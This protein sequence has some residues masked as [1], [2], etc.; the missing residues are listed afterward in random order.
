MPDATDGGTR[1]E[2][3]IARVDA[4]GVVN[5]NARAIRA[6]VSRL[7]ENMRRNAVLRERFFDNPRQVLGAVGLNEEIQNE[8]LQNEFRLG[9]TPFFQSRLLGWCICTDCCT[10]SCCITTI[11]F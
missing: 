4:N 6:V 1:E 11:I 2:E 8:L 3:M 10:T 5:L 7:S 9:N